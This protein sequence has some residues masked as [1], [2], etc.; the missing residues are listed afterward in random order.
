L[1]VWEIHPVMQLL[2]ESSIAGFAPPQPQVTPQIEPSPSPVAP[3]PTAPSEEFVTIIRPVTIQIPYGR[4]IL[5]SGM[6][7]PVVSRDAQTVRV[8]YMNEVYVLPL[9]STDLR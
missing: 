4:T 9:S 8:R 1:A 2:T 7:L 3:V 6:R 5:P